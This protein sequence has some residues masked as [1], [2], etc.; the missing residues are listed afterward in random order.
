VYTIKAIETEYNGVVFR[1]RLEAHWA[2]FFDIVGWEW[3]YEPLDLCKWIPDFRV[4]FPCGHSECPGYH[5]L[6]VEVKPYYSI[7]EF[8]GHPCL[9][10]PYG[11]LRGSTIPADSSAAFGVN[12]DVTWWE[13]VHGNGGGVE[14]IK[15]GWVNRDIDIDLAW[16]QAGFLTRYNHAVEG[17]SPFRLTPVVGDAASPPSVGEQTRAS[18]QA[19]EGSSPHPPRA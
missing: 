13:M 18:G 7:D 6:L 4:K 8:E 10:Y 12:P 16:K 1:S 9:Q 15:N 11:G 14:A 5:V 2:A 3:E 17:E 19:G